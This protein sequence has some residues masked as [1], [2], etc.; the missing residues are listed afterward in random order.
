MLILG[1]STN[2]EDV[3]TKGTSN[4]VVEPLLSSSTAATAPL[5]EE[6]VVEHQQQEE[7]AAADAAAEAA[8]VEVVTLDNRLQAELQGKLIV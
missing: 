6:M 8:A 3:S 2:V 7:E 4:S 1:A 5:E